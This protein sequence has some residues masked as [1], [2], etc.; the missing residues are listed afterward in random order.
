MRG[1][2]AKSGLPGRRYRAGWTLCSSVLMKNNDETKTVIEYCLY[3][4]SI[5]K[6]SGILL[7]AWDKKNIDKTHV[8]A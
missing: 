2:Q 3:P 7:P 8:Q 6:H 4:L 1:T 5:E